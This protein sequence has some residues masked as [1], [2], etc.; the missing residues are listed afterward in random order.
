MAEAMIPL[1]EIRERK[2]RAVRPDPA[3]LLALTFTRNS[4]NWRHEA[5]SLSSECPNPL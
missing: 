5:N 3:L 2:A 1:T 4:S